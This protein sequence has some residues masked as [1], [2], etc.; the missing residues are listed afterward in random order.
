[1]SLHRISLLHMVAGG[2]L[3]A[4][5]VPKALLADFRGLCADGHLVQLCTGWVLTTSGNKIILED[6]TQ[7]ESALNR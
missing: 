3:I 1:M 4:S 7:S 2:G 5:R 6:N